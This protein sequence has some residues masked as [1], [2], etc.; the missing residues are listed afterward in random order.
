MTIAKLYVPD[1]ADTTPINLSSKYLG[2][3]GELLKNVIGLIEEHH[4][5]YWIDGGTLLGAFRDKKHIPYDDDEDLGMPT[6]DFFQFRKYIKELETRYNYV[7]E[8]TKD[9]II[10][11]Y[12]PSASYVRN[13]E[14]GQTYPRTACVDIFHYTY[15]KK[16]KK[17]VLSLPRMRDI[18]QNC[19]Y[20]MKDLYPLKDYEYGDL[21][22]KGAQNPDQFL[23]LYYGNWKERIVYIYI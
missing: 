5:E 17:Y 8:D 13:K 22:L 11:I 9:E 18:Y 16:D 7:V 21:V 15:L 19:E 12:D 3:L 4:L 20:N 10:K 2:K 6:Y 14:S 23:T 1:N